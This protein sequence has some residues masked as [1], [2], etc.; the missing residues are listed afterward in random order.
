MKSR[1]KPA[2]FLVL[3]FAIFSCKNDGFI[4]T[5]SGLKYK[6]VRSGNGPA[7]KSGDYVVFNMEYYDEDD[8]LIYSSIVRGLPVTMLYNDSLW[9]HSGQ[10]YEGFSKLKVGD[11]AIMK[12][13]CRDLYLN[14][15]RM[16][17][18]GKLD[19]AG[20]ITFRIGVAG[21][22]NEDE[23]KEFQRHLVAKRETEREEREKKQ[24]IEDTA[25]I[26]R[27]LE[28]E[29]IIPMETESG[30]RYIIEKEGTGPKP[31]KGDKVEVKFKGMLLDGTVF[32]SS[33][34]TGK[35]M[36]FPVGQGVVIKGWDEGI[37]MMRK[38]SRYK[39]Y[40]P[41]P[42]AYGGRSIGSFIAPNSILVYDTELVDIK[43][44]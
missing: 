4:R 25:I 41:S 2:F 20:T 19:P 23:F 17:V 42:L 28:G 35:P 43:S 12:V 16:P 29:N 1:I 9:N 33:E 31:E 14:S 8:S 7:F 37:S 11:S 13:S 39:F 5:G 38:G 36:E 24:L 21:T 18:P 32:D 15:F 40:I 10:A 6:I 26:D 30:L 44:N 34:K 27:Y 3:A 22:M